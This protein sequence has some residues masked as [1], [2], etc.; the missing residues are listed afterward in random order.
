[1]Q[2]FIKSKKGAAELSS[3]FECVGKSD[4]RTPLLCA[5]KRRDAITVELV[6]GVQTQVPGQQCG[7]KFWNAACS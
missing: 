1:M 6:N 3:Y 5:V 2:E 4:G 7:L